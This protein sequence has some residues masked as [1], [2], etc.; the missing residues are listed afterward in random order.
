MKNYLQ[1]L[2]KQKKPI[3][4]VM[5]RLLVKTGLCHF[6]VIKQNGYSLHFSQS[7]LAEQ[8][9]LDPKMREPALQ[10]F[11]SYLRAGD[12]VVDVGANIGDT[13]LVS[14]LEVGATGTVIAIEAHPHTFANF[15]KNLALNNSEA[16]HP[17]NVAVGEAQG[18]VSFGNDRRDDMNKVGAGKLEVSMARLDDIIPLDTQYALLKIDVEGY[19]L[20]ALKG[21][22]KLLAH[23]ECIYFEV[24]NEM[25]EF[26]NYS[27]NELLVF[28][29]EQG[30]S[31]Y[32]QA[33]PELLL[34]IAV[35]TPITG[36]E[37]LIAAKHENEL[38]KRTGWQV[39]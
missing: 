19:E 5:A 18:K 29:S 13:A 7:N 9:W 31:V 39:K 17:V 4:F 37:N 25:C 1:I 26:F 15:V 10:F 33:S 24:S 34:K 28:I 38:I 16:I 8:L 11:R 20:P 21:A 27:V 6:F 36:V 14:S 30:F 35:D 23:V 12:H 3:R 32:K 22:H 2:A